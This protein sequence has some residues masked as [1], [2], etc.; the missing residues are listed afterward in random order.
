M[1][2]AKKGGRRIVVGGT[3][4][5]WNVRSRPTYSQALAEKPLSFAVELEAS[6]QSVLVVNTDSARPDSWLGVK[7]GVVTPVV[8]ERAIRE[9]LERGWEPTKSGSPFVVS[10]ISAKT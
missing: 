4:Y 3:A 1:A 6:G 8:V 7:R 10:N 5:R 9:A 2:I